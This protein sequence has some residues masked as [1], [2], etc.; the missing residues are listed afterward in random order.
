MYLTDEVRAR[1]HPKP[2]SQSQHERVVVRADVLERVGVDDEQ[3]LPVHRETSRHVARHQNA[4]RAL[5]VLGEVVLAFEGCH[6]VHANGSSVT[7]VEER[8]LAEDLGVPIARAVHANLRA[9]GQAVAK[10]QANLGRRVEAEKI[11]REIP[12]VSLTERPREAMGHPKRKL[13]NR[14][15]ERRWQRRQVEVRLQRID[16][17]VRIRLLW[18]IRRGSLR[19]R[20][21]LEWEWKDL[22]QPRGRAQAHTPAPEPRYEDTSSSQLYRKG[23]AARNGRSP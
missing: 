14:H 8:V 5:K 23:D 22:E 7:L 6:D 17:E 11:V 15:P 19:R 20:R 10:F 18:L 21:S 3:R 4:E 13:V 12:E 1:P 9:A 16:P 2:R